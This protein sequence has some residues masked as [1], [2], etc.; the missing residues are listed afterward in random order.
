MKAKI[1]IKETVTLTLSQP[2]SK[3][4]HITVVGRCGVTQIIRSKQDAK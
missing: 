3:K 2:A 4:E 1:G